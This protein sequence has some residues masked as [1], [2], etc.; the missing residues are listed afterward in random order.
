MHQLKIISLTVGQMATNCY[1]LADRDTGEGIVVDPGDDAEYISDRLL[2]EK[3]TPSLVVATHGHFDHI[4]GAFA[5]TAGF[6]I[7]FAIHKNDEFLVARMPQTARHFLGVASDPAP[8]VSR[9]LTEGDIL[10]VGTHELTVMET[11]GHTPGSVCIYDKVENTL[12]CGD[13]LFSGGGVGRTD[14]EYASR[15]DLVRSIARVM[16]L[17]GRTMLYCGHGEMTT[18]GAE[19]SFH[20]Q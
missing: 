8:L 3:I 4:M 6:G 7:P 19:S 11:P 15:T 1:I 16:K 17:P 14:H 20:V 5:V 18:I 13:L 12:F 9:Y 2:R 10:Q